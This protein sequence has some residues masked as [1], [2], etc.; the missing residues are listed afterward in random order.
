GVGEALE[1]GESVLIFPEGTFTSAP[2]IRPFQLGAFKS[3][4]LAGRPICPVAVR[5]ARE[6]LRDKTLL[7]K[8][9]RI[10]VQFGPLVEPQADAV[11]HTGDGAA[12]A[13]WRE[14]VRMRDAVREIIGKNTGEPLL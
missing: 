4:V 1:R 3:A 12:Q 11:E 9:G 7:P 13:D 14:I 6:I 8:F 2:G 5:G 10:E